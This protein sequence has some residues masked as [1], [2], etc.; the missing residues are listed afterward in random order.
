MAQPNSYKEKKDILEPKKK[1]YVTDYA[2]GRQLRERPEEESRQIFEKRLVDEYGY[3]KN[4]L[5]IEFL[6]QKG[7]KRIGPADIVVFRDNKKTFDNIYIIVETKRKEIKDGLDQLK[8]YLSPTSAEFGVWFNGKDMPVY[9]QNLKKAPYFRG[10]PDI[11]KKGE[12]LED[13]GLYQKKDLVPATELRSVFEVCH[14]YIYAN[15][16]LLKEKTFNEVLKLIF[17]KMADEKKSDPKCEFRITD[18]EL[19]ELEEGKENGFTDR[20]LNLFKD[21]KTRYSDV[22]D[23]NERINLKPLTIAF[24]V[25]QLQKYSLINTEADVKGTA[26]QTFVYAHQRG[27]RGE[28]FTPHPIVEL[29]VKMLNPKD[30]EKFIDPACGSG[31]FLVKGM[32]YIKEKFISDNPHRK[33]KANDFLKEYAHAYISGIDINPDLAKV[34]KMH[35]ILYDD[36]HSGIF[37]ENSL[38]D[39]DKLLKTAQTMGVPRAIQPRPN[40]FQV[41]MTNPPFGTKGKVTSKRILENFELGYKWK[42]EKDGTWKKTNKIMD[43]QVPDIMFIERCLQLLDNHGRMAI[44]LPDGDLTNSSLEY[45]REFIKQKARVLAVVSLPPETF[46]PHGT[47]VK[48]SVLF[49]QKLS[50]EELENLKEKDYPIFMAICEKIGY[51]VRGRTLYKKDEK[52]ELIRDEKEKRIVDRDINEIVDGFENFKRR[53]GLRF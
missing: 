37:A 22:F 2:T 47:G 5:E 35:M 51:D 11:P 33:N 34:A 43:G 3:S 18:K 13:V 31:G 23:Q 9:L 40:T 44:V 7:S 39:F 19:K 15:E 32:N 30:N 42:K 17:I 14:N 21:V 53:Y 45:I 4:Q 50:E 16:G 6:I 29:A 24:I 46:I 12:T 41:L 28:F 49:L 27:E 48:A 10:V 8:S 25:S 36:G 1:G 20:I 26:F 38:D 52:G